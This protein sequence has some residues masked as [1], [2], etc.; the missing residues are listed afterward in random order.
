MGIS[1]S[2]GTGGWS[3]GLGHSPPIHHFSGSKTMANDPR[4]WVGCQWEEST[5]VNVGEWKWTIVFMNCDWTICNC[6]PG[7]WLKFIYFLSCSY[8]WISHGSWVVQQILSHGP[9]VVRHPPGLWIFHGWWVI[10]Q[11]FPHG[12]WV[13]QQLFP[14]GSWVIQQVFSHGLGHTTALHSWVT[15]WWAIGHTPPHFSQMLLI[16]MLFQDQKS[17][18]K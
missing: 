8:W 5:I 15:G 11:L 9:W 16:L 1:H 17:L 12:S 7:Y 10:Q 14:H 4:W 18:S 13:I 6:C 3:E 2:C